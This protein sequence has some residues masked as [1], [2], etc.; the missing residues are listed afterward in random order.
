MLTSRRGR[1]A[2]AICVAV[3]TAGA[4]PAFAETLADAIALA[5]DTNP[6]LQAQRA[7]QRA[8]D[9]T[10][11]QARSGWRPTL[12]ASVGDTFLESRTPRLGA[13]G[14]DSNN[15]GVPDSASRGGITE[16]YTGNAF[17]TFSQPIFTGGRVGA[18]VSAAQADILNGREG[19]RRIEQQVLGAVIQAYSAVRRDQ[20]AVRIR[21]DDVSVLQ[22]QLDESN[23]RFD[24]G[25]ITRTDVAQS[26]ARLANAV[27]LLQ[28]AQAQLATSR[29][30]YAAVVGQNPGD[31][32]P[33]PSL[34][35]LLP[36]DVDRAFDLAE[37]NNPQ[38]RSAEYAERASRARVAGAKAERMP[39]VSLSADYGFSGPGRSIDTDTWSQT[40][41]ARAGVTM[42]LFSGGLVSSR[43][44]QQVERNNADRIGIEGARR[45]VLQNLTQSWNQMMAAR[46]NIAS[47]DEQAR[48][49]AI[50]AEG[51]RQEQQVGLR[52]TLDVL[53][54]Q[55]ELRAAQL[56]QVNA[57]YDEYVSAAAVLSA[58]GRLEARNLTPTT[59]QYDP[60]TNFKKLRVTWGWVPWEEPIARADSILAGKV[61]ELPLEGPVGAGSAPQPEKAAP[62]ASPKTDEAPAAAK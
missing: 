34:G 61:D 28:S 57:R 7:T 51:T 4:A 32:A 13:G 43:I 44:R 23:A 25:E 48:A 38:I 29:A 3:A 50:A 59:P 33:E 16:T 58:M 11:V 19:L 54:A 40:I 35:H 39:Q 30:T 49:A 8:L 17:L 47:S 21:Q 6:T 56:A 2:G 52:T 36:V 18:A 1:L 45:Q 27:S 55:A 12:S 60:K 26:Q 37:Q 31:L 9:E 42:P 14:V 41:R 46:A 22:R 62:A 20:E 53:N 5:Y 10:Y 24:V 15:D